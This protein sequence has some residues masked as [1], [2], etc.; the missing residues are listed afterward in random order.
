M[1]KNAPDFTDTFKLVESDLLQDDLEYAQNQ[2]IR[3]KMR[4]KD[5][6]T[7]NS[8]KSEESE[9]LVVKSEVEKRKAFTLKVLE[10]NE[11]KF[12]QLFNQLQLKGDCRRKQQLADEALELLFAKYRSVL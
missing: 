2:L 6:H 8:P 3:R 9:K 11:K 4:K 10:R 7:S 12:H 1:S 5:A